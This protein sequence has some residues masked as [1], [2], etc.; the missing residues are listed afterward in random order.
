MCQPKLS[1]KRQALLAERA[2]AMRHAPTPPEAILWC[3]LSGNKL[4]VAFRRQVPLAGRYIADFFAPA[5]RL[6]VEVD[7]A[8]HLRQ[9]T[10]D[11]RRDRVLARQGLRVLRL[12]A[13]LV[14]RQ[15]LVAVARIREALGGP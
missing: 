12:P 2:H 13:S 3:H 14:M 7:G 1:R 6:V 4:G 10:A 5:A 8:S 15:P 9:V 11:A